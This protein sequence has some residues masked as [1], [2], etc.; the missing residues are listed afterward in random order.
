MIEWRGPP[1]KG[2]TIET[3]WFWGTLNTFS[4]PNAGVKVWH[5]LEVVLTELVG[6]TARRRP[7]SATGFELL[8]P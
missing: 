1:A 3:A 7:D 5:V 8:E 4:V 2:V 6:S